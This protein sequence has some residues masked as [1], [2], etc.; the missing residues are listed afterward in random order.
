MFDKF[1][2]HLAHSAPD[3]SRWDGFDRGDTGRPDDFEL[4][5][6]FTFAQAHAKARAMAMAGARRVRVVRVD[7]GEFEVVV[8]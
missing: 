5:E 6:F 3:N 4:P 1:A 2:E 7:D 8:G